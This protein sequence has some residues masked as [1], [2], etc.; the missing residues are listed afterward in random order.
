MCQ[1]AAN[2][3]MVCA[4][5]ADYYWN[6]FH[7]GVLNFDE[8]TFGYISC[9]STD[10]WNDSSV[11]ETYA[12][13]GSLSILAALVALGGG[14][15]SS[16]QKNQA[17]MSAAFS[18]LNLAAAV[19]MFV[20]TKEFTKEG[21]EKLNKDADF[22]D[23]MD[24]SED[25][26]I[27]IGLLHAF[28]FLFGIVYTLCIRCEL[29]IKESW[30]ISRQ[31]NNFN[32]VAAMFLY[33]VAQAVWQYKILHELDCSTDPEELSKSMKEELEV[34]MDGD[35]EVDQSKRCVAYA[36]SGTFLIIGALACLVALFLAFCQETARQGR[37]QQFALAFSVA[38]ACL[39]WTSEF[40]YNYSVSGTGYNSCMD[41]D[42]LSSGRCAA[43]FFGG[44]FS[45]VGF[46][47]ALFTAFAFLCGC[48]TDLD[49]GRLMISFATP[50]RGVVNV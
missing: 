4:C 30:Q 3:L 29:C 46:P 8:E 17:H 49:E 20:M 16:F 35:H 37:V 27:V 22:D 14:L 21:Q 23:V 48:M 18:L 28:G 42:F 9:E 33:L 6:Y 44:M 11:C 12:A 36:F 32:Y 50:S 25:L 38:M 43:A 5:W 47:L 19:F 10:K 40:W 41:E 45:I 34:Q 15:Y 24:L 13:S 1:N 31:K 39:A 2:K 7:I 26:Y